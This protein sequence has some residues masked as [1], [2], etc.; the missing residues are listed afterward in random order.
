MKTHRVTES[1]VQ[2]DLS[3][4]RCKTDSEHLGMTGWYRESL[5]HTD[6]SAA[7]TRALRAVLNDRTA[8]HPRDW[9]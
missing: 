9:Q 7:C 1:A 8:I 5:T 4:F 3:L 6:D 2:E